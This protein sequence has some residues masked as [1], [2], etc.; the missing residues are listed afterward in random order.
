M[1]KINFHKLS[2]GHIMQESGPRGSISGSDCHDYGSI[3]GCDEGCPALHAGDCPEVVLALEVCDMDPEEKRE[4]TQ[5][6]PATTP[7]GAA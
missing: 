3:S 4:I 7:G 2:Y 5:L 6:Y 1:S